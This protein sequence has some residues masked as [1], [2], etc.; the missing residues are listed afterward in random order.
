MSF[1]KNKLK[2]IQPISI[3]GNHI[4]K[5]I[6]KVFNITLEEAEK[7]K[8]SFNKSETEFSYANNKHETFFTAKDIINKKI[9]IDLLKKVIL[10]RVQEIIDLSFKKTSSNNYK[11]NLRD[12]DLF[13]IGD[14]SVLFN[15]NSFYL[16]DKF[17]FNSI[18]FYKETDVEICYS[19]LL[20]YLN[21]YEVS[22]KINKKRGFFE[23]FFNFFSK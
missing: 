5:D 8:R 10:Y 9:S 3:G 12:T 1:N 6:S 22:K 16:D 23:K 7:I 19:V 11:L 20:Y 18:N 21:K 17:Q 14:G 4:T 13:L 2:F 15:N